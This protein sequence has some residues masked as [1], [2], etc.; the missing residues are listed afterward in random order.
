MI[1]AIAL[2]SALGADASSGVG[3]VVLR[4]A[5]V[6]RVETEIRGVV[7]DWEMISRRSRPDWVSQEWYDRSSLHALG[8]A[9][10]SRPDLLVDIRSYQDAA[11]ASK[12]LSEG[13]REVQVGPTGKLEGIGEE[14]WYTEPAV[15]VVPLQL[16]FRIGP[17]LVYVHSFG[18]DR[19]VL[20][21][22]CVAIEKG[23]ESQ[24]WGTPG[25]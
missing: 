13:V 9:P 2:A 15:A 24:S 8:A 11:S 12:A 25:R 7:P 14:G 18:L 1:L 5:L 16:V 4:R 17:A 10:R 21:K 20:R 22:V 19:A 3:H 6:A 23:F